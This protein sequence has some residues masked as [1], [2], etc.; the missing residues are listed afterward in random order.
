MVYNKY[1]RDVIGNTGR[2]VNNTVRIEK[3]YPEIYNNI[4]P[5][6]TEKIKKLNTNNITKGEIEKI[7]NDIYFKIDNQGMNKSFGSKKY[8]PQIR[9]IA[10]RDLIW[11]ILVQE[12]FKSNQISLNNMEY[13]K[14][15]RNKIYD[16]GN[17]IY[18]KSDKLG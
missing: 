14:S 12:L 10:L 16:S 5:L 7:A 1:M 6:L 9:N 18:E 17:N 11:I 13:F 2:I 3:F 4:Y 8:T 15:V